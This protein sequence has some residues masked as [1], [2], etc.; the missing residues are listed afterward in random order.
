MLGAE[1][2]SGTTEE[3]HHTVIL[4]WALDVTVSQLKDGNTLRYYFVTECNSGKT[5]GRQP[6]VIFFWV[7]DITVAQLKDGNTL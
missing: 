2:N 5:E 6:T 1:F 3:R 4:C 7:L